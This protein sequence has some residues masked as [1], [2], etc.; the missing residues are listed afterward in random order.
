MSQKVQPSGDQIQSSSK[1]EALTILNNVSHTSFHA[2]NF[3]Y[4]YWTFY[5]MCPDTGSSVLNKLESKTGTIQI[6]CLM[7]SQLITQAVEDYFHHRFVLSDTRKVTCVRD[8][9]AFVNQYKQDILHSVECQQ[10]TKTTIEE[11]EKLV[12]SHTSI[13]G[14]EWGWYIRSKKLFLK[15][16]VDIYK[17]PDTPVIRLDTLTNPNRSNTSNWQKKLVK[18]KQLWTFINKYKDVLE[19]KIELIPTPNPIREIIT[20]KLA[21]LQIDEITDSNKDKY[22]IHRQY[23]HLFIRHSKEKRIAYQSCKPPEDKYK[24]VMD[25]D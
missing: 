10:K 13:A 1:T 14:T 22:K 17:D 3:K 7:D 16:F 25:L 15:I 20:Q 24:Y 18:Q 23:E 9:S 8:I 5:T 12:G 21:D 4:E 2:S 11:L 19:D 6:R